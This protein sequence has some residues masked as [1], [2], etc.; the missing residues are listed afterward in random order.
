MIETTVTPSGTTGTQGYPG[1]GNKMQGDCSLALL[2]AAE[3]IDHDNKVVGL[4]TIDFRRS[5]RTGLLKIIYLKRLAYI[6]IIFFCDKTI[7]KR[8]N[9]LQHVEIRKKQTITT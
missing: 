3:G 9:Y 2:R 4:H 6:K 1:T 5:D 8:N 7:S